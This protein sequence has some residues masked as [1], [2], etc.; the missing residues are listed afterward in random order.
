[1]ANVRAGVGLWKFRGALPDTVRSSRLIWLANSFLLRLEWDPR[2]E[3]VKASCSLFLAF[4]GACRNTSSR[5]DGMISSSVKASP[6]FQ[7]S[8]RIIPATTVTNLVAA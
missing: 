4:G 2:S 7:P 3:S 5:L 8:V 6:G 1:M